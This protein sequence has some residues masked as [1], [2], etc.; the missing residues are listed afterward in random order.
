[1][2]RSPG[3]WPPPFRN[4]TCSQSPPSK[5]QTTHTLSP[6]SAQVTRHRAPIRT[7]LKLRNWNLPFLHNS[8]L[9]SPPARRGGAPYSAR[10]IT[11]RRSTLV[12]ASYNPASRPE[13][14]LAWGL[15][16]A[17]GAFADRRHH[18]DLPQG[19]GRMSALLSLL[20]R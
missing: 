2:H 13:P 20:V 19:E 12:S 3:S 7:K 16:L 18:L 10:H 5:L 6:P 11:C 1:M 14:H 9:P 17:L 8:S 4:R 15:V